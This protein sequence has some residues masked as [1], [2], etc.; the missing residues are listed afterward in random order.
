MVLRKHLSEWLEHLY[1]DRFKWDSEE[2]EKSFA[3]L[4]NKNVMFARHCV[5][6]YQRMR[7]ETS[8]EDARCIS[9]HPTHRAWKTAGS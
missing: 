9:R 7:S 6:E 8:A 5:S 2:G 3:H 4:F 1:E